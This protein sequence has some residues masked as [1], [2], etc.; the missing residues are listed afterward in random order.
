MVQSR[1]VI[2]HT[3]ECGL[4]ESIEPIVR[5]TLGTLMRSNNIFSPQYA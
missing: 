1:N 4:E 2:L 3:L 5:P